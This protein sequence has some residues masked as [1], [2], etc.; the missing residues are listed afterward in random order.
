MIRSLVQPTNLLPL[1]ALQ[2]L[3]MTPQPLPSPIRYRL[4]PNGVKATRSK[5]Q[6]ACRLPSAHLPILLPEIWSGSANILHLLLARTD[7][8]GIKCSM[9]MGN[10]R[11]RV[12]GWMLMMVAVPRNSSLTGLLPPLSSQHT[13]FHGRSER[14][15]MQRCT[16]GTP[17][18]ILTLT[19]VVVHQNQF[20]TA[21]KHELEAHAGPAACLIP[22]HDIPHRAQS[23][24]ATAL[25]KQP[26]VPSMYVVCSTYKV[27]TGPP[28]NKADSVY[29]IIV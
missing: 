21:A 15:P 26:A 1:Q 18:Q 10:N 5:L 27:P 3:Q 13:S 14:L 7:M 4:Q 28:A 12:C 9:M 11:M 29:D 20:S 6:S 16:H 24:V 8:S 19:G 17:D 25:I 2:A 23:A 22:T